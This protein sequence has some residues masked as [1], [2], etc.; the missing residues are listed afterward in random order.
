MTE[1]KKFLYS[2]LFFTVVLL[3]V[4]VFIRKEKIQLSIKENKFWIHKTFSYKKYDHLIMG[5]SRIYRSVIPD[6]LSN[7]LEFLNVGYSSAG[8]SKEYISHFVH[9]N[10]KT[11]IL[12]ITP[13]AFTRVAFKNEHFSTFK[14]VGLIDRSLMVNEWY[15]LLFMPF[16]KA[17]KKGNEKYFESG[18]VVKKKYKDKIGEGVNKY[19]DIFKKTKFKKSLFRETLNYLK[20]FKDI[21]I[22]AFRTP[23]SKEMRD[24]EDKVSGFDEEWVRAELE[25]VGVKWIEI[26]SSLNLH[27]YDDSHL[28][29]RSAKELSLY[30]SKKI[31]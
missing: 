22:Y 21:K 18:Y 3:S 17:M 9:K 4:N 11:L 6:L 27:S 16:S 10:T 30:L 2:F 28:D 12:G 14:K 20:S 13:H 1:S 24:L 29:L 23:T 15:Q 7:D 31:L 5:D 8:L 25:Q 26:P 19:R